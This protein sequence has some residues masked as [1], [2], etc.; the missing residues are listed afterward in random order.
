[1]VAR[2]IRCILQF[3]SDIFKEMGLRFESIRRI[4]SPQC[5]YPIHITEAETC[6]IE[7]RGVEYLV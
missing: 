7:L 4:T 5:I 6:Y 1:M 3:G 2:P